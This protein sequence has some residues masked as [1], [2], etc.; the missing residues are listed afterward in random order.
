MPISRPDAVAPVAAG[1]PRTGGAAA[2]VPV[3]RLIYRSHSLIMPVDREAAHGEIFRISRLNNAAWGVTGALLLHEDC[4]CQTLEG[5]ESAVRSLFAII[6]ADRRH[7]A[8]EIVDIATVAM[9]SF[10]RWSMAKVSDTDGDVHLV[11]TRMGT[12][13]TAHRGTTAEQDR[14]LMVM[15]ALTLDLARSH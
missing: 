10:A 14:L 4:I 13:V 11:A 8:V 3:F 15:R 5:E 2:R 7:H 6:E 9:P 12:T 1:D